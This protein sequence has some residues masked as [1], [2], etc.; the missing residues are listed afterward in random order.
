MD[1]LTK[2]SSSKKKIIFHI[3]PHLHL[4]K[5]ESEDTQK[6]EIFNPADS[7]IGAGRISCWGYQ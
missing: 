5:I 2:G 4:R 7:S 6:L 3:H 1:A